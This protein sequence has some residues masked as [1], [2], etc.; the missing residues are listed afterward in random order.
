[1]GRTYL[2]ADGPEIARRR[3]LV[4]AG[5]LV[6]AWP[7]LYVAG[8]FWLGS[9]SK[10]LLDATGTP[11]R[12]RLSLDGG[13]VPIYYGPRLCDLES[14]PLEESLQ[15]RALSARGVAVAWI[16]LDRFGERTVHRAESP[17]DPVF[18]LRRPRGGA[19]HQWRLFRTKQEAVTYM[20]ESY[21]NDSEAQD[22]ASGLSVESYDELLER[23]AR[24]EADTP[25]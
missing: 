24:R 15:A 7:D 18:F 21:G 8:D 22:W 6:E 11:L 3:K 19:A 10:A 2:S 5:N 17:L 16:T 20:R 14:L 13:F 12:A 1:M 23:H 9:E 25:P 4:P